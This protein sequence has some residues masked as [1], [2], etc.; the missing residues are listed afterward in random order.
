M[1]KKGF[2]F[3][4]LL[5]ILTNNVLVAQV[6]FVATIVPNEIGKNEFAQLKLSVENAQNVEKIV[7][8]NLNN[9]IVESGPNQETGFSD[10]NGVVKKHVALTYIIRPKSTGTITIPS[11]TAIADGV[12]YKSNSIKIKVGNISVGNSNAIS[13]FGNMGIMPEPQT[14]Y[15]DHIIK[16]GENAADKARQNMFVKVDVTKTTCFVGEPIV[17]T[18]KLYT[19][20]KS[21]SNVVKSPS[22]NGF[23]VIDLE[24]PNSMYYSNETFKGKEYNVYTLRKAQLY[25]LQA[26]TFNLDEA[27]IENTVSFIKE[28]YIK[29]GTQNL[30][31]AFG[32]AMVP[33]TA[34]EKFKISLKNNSVSILVKPLPSKN[35]PVSFKGAVGRFQINATLEK[36]KFTTDETA[37]LRI[38]LSGEGNLHLINIPEVKWPK[39]IEVF[40]PNTKEDLFKTTVPV[41]GTKIIEYP[42]VADSVGNYLLDSLRCSYFDDKT[43]LY[44]TIAVKPIAFTVSKGVLNK[45]KANTTELQKS[46]SWLNSF[47]SNRRLVIS[48]LQLLLN[49]TFFWAR[50]ISKKH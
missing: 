50:K 32:E 10:V 26:G 11:T 18:Y 20:L 49:C 30:F 25:P 14:N 19:R 24:Q 35:I 40:E 4:V 16:K 17:A 28:E 9:F 13:P 42:L 38:T 27:E 47:F 43:N 5:F 8:P 39:N 3:F 44:K 48:F 46:T 41:S 6:K 45:E 23:S 36:D 31:N 34:F 12:E 15:K 29:G 7:T 33:E 2:S 22:F 1:L 37:K 21:E